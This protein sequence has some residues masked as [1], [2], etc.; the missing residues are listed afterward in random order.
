MIQPTKITR[1]LAF[2]F[3]LCLMGVGTAAL[4]GEAQYKVELVWGTDDAKAASPD[5]KALS[6]DVQSRLTQLRWKNY[7][8]V[9]SE[10]AAVSTKEAKKVTL[11]DKCAVELK[12]LPN[13]HL[14]VQIHS[15]Q[16]GSDPKPVASKTMSL[17]N[18][19]SGELIAYGGNSKDRWGDAWLVIVRAE[20]P[21]ASK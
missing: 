5:M 12:E 18:L 11:S 7:F 20:Q 16:A 17:K 10:V 9:K 4:A 2:L 8:V 19:Q 15:L 1:W 13:G 6:P 21:K 14:E 3:T